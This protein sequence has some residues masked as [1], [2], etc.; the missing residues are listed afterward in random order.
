[1]RRFRFRI[2]TLLV[3]IIVLGVGFAALRE[4]NDIWDS[5]GF[6]LALAALLVS[7]LLAIHRT[8]KRRAFWV[9]FAL[10]GCGY[11]ALSL[12]PPIGS[13]LITTKL[14]AYIDS[15]VPRSTPTRFVYFDYD[16]DGDMDLH[17]VNNSKP[18]AVYLNRG[19][20]TF[21][22]VATTL[23]LNSADNQVGGRGRL[24]FNN[25]AGPWLRGSSGTSELD[26]CRFF[27]FRGGE[28]PRCNGG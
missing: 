17:V 10:F 15:K 5:G 28:P 22:D 24:F 26:S 6:T 9:G 3:L 1:M 8:G 23:E 18:S 13:R 14:L 4:S 7:I 16:N 20:G 12:V 21:E 11:L 25:S 2:G 19:N 27:G